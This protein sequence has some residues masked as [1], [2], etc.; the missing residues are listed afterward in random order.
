MGG[1]IGCKVREEVCSLL[2][3]NLLPL[4]SDW[5]SQAAGPNK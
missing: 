4:M 5:E 3:I 2:R 1:T